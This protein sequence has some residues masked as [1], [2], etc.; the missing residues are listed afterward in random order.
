MLTFTVC[1]PG[2]GK[3]G[4]MPANEAARASIARTWSFGDLGALLNRLRIAP[5][6]MASSVVAL[7]VIGLALKGFE[8]LAFTAAIIVL[9]VALAF[10][11]AA[12]QAQNRKLTE[13]NW[14]LEQRVFERTRDLV[15]AKERAEA[16]DR[17]KSLFLA[18]MSHE[19]RTPLNSIIGFT[20]ILLQG[21]GGPINEE[22]RKQLSMVKVS[23]QHLLTLI[24][25]ILDISK[26]EAGQLTVGR[27]P[28]DLRA[29]MAKVVQSI[30]PLAERQGLRLG[31]EVGDGVDTCTGDA[32][33]VEQVLLNLV[34]N[35]VK[36]TE[37]G[38]VEVRCERHPEGY[39]ITVTDSGIGIADVDLKHL[40]EPFRQLDSGLS[41]KY[42]GTGL[43]LSISRKLVELMGGCIWVESEK[44]KGSRFGFTLPSGG[45]RA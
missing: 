31:L 10:A 39:G 8:R 18:T 33:R 21:L 25:D 4:D 22:Q 20:G 12:I 24:S 15:E 44:G 7:L 27:E 2:G 40:F 42:E 23:A 9:S 37:Q 16:A 3:M 17:V 13:S 19:L 11:F 35:A 29:S 32:R 5:V 26:I 1:E 14:R 34:S 36:F 30:R 6:A 45:E 28:F 43:G 38:S 41:R